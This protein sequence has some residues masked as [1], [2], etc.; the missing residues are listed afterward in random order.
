MTRKDLE[1]KVD[2]FFKKYLG[3]EKGYPTDAQYK[4]ECPSIVKLYM[5]EVF[6]FNPPPSGVNSAYGYWTNFPA[7]L[8]KYFK[9]VPNT[10]TGVPK[11]GD[12]PIWQPSLI[13]SEGYGHIN[14][15][16]GEG[17]TSMFKGFDQNWGG[18]KAHYQNHSYI[19][20]YGW[21][22][23]ILKESSAAPVVSKHIIKPDVVTP[24]PLPVV[25]TPNIPKPAI[26]IPTSPSIDVIPQ[27]SKKVGIWQ[28]ILEKIFIFLFTEL[29]K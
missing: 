21:L 27:E 1:F 7:P 29:P 2:A 15:A 25:S 18:K 11:K 12:I 23:P 6:G 4:G 8:S 20:L 17:N 14:I 24:K 10:P 9:K 13:G 22:T 26:V 16:A 28:K 19:A 5:K 3:Q